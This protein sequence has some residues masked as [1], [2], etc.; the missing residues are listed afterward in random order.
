MK[1]FDAVVIGG[2]P[3]GLAASIAAARAGLSVM[4][5]DVHV[6]PIDKLCGEGLLPD[7]LQ[8]LGELGVGS[9]RGAPFTGISFH[10]NE[11]AFAGSFSGQGAL[12]VRRT[13]LHEAL[14]AAAEREG[15]KLFWRTRAERISTG[16]VKVGAETFACHYVI[17]ADGMHSRVRQSAGLSV[18]ASGPRGLRERQ[19]LASG[20][21]YRCAP[22]SRNVEVHWAGSVQAYVTPVAGDEVSVAVISRAR[23]VRAQESLDLFPVL[24]A[25]LAAAAR[26]SREQGA[27]SMMLR[28]PRV[29]A[30]DTIL[31]GEASGSV[32]AITGEGLSL[33]FR[34][35]LALGDALRS[36]DLDAYQKEH[37]RILWRSRWMAR[38]LLSLSEQPRW[39]SRVFAAFVREPRA[40]ENLLNMHVGSR[41]KIFGAG[42]CTDLCAQV[43]FG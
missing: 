20:C 39:R 18:R 34:Q 21:H 33:V 40:F 4:V 11:R 10:E 42:G 12:G 3:A 41:P 31:I 2:G 37:R 30:G 43:L 38:M 16:K 22:W 32:D 7:A 14:T 29:V 13:L 15:V 25:R 23:Q 28:L 17:G 26:V 6:P 35:A 24:R 9:L 19:R 36:G 8:A 5:A 1:R 27:A